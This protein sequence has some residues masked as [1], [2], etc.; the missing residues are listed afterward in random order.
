MKEKR[1][2]AER[3]SRRPRER[4][5]GQ[6]ER[7]RRRRQTAHATRERSP[8]NS[9]RPNQVLVKRA[10]CRGM[11][12]RR[13]R[14]LPPHRL[15]VG[16]TGGCS[17]AESGERSSRFFRHALSRSRAWARFVEAPIGVLREEPVICR[18]GGAS[19]PSGPK[20]CPL[21]IEAFGSEKR[22]FDSALVA[23]W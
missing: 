4:R 23:L 7:R 21:R 13:P 20:P 8:I 22:T 6:I 1:K 19:R 10:C 18:E 5:R 16:Q 2:K 9:R 3:S 17:P 15:N 12:C 11:A 14:A